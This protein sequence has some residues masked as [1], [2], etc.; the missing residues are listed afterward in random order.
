MVN[1]GRIVAI[2][3]CLLEY[4]FEDSNKLKKLLTYV[5]YFVAIQHATN[6]TLIIVPIIKKARKYYQSSK[7]VIKG[8]KVLC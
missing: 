6:D 3:D 8:K 5:N 2:N 7:V 4:A 1:A